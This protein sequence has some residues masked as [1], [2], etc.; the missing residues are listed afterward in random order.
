M[1][2]MVAR[3]AAAASLPSGRARHLGSGR[4][5]LAPA[6]PGHGAVVLA[7][8]RVGTGHGGVLV[9]QF[10][11]STRDAIKAAGAKVASGTAPDSFGDADEFKKAVQ[12][13][14]KDIAERC[15]ALTY[16]AMRRLPR[17][18]RRRFENIFWHAHRAFAIVRSRATE[19]RATL[20]MALVIAQNLDVVRRMVSSACRT[21]LPVDMEDSEPMTPFFSVTVFPL[22]GLEM[23]VFTMID[24]LYLTVKSD[25]DDMISAAA[26]AQ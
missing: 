23:L 17:A 22:G 15:V 5:P 14:L 25:I 4:L 21:P 24:N 8:R 9:A 7:G 13:K 26:A 11:G 3:A 18:E 16:D 20:E 1:A 12:A 6:L 2:S 19:G 10:M